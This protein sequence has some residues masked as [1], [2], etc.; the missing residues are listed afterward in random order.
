[1]DHPAPRLAGS[2]VRIL[3]ERDVRAG[4]PFLVGV[5]EVV[6]GRVVLVDGLLH[7][8]QAED[9][10]VEVDVARRVAR[11]ARHVMDAVEPHALARIAHARPRRP[12]RCFQSWRGLLGGGA[13][14]APPPPPRT[15]TPPPGPP[16]G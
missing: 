14:W 15:P 13:G 9:A 5:E 4:P 16:R 8:P 1:M 3:E 11:D 7:E 10:R 2:R 6:D 12:A